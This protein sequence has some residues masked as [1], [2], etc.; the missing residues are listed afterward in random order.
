M[1]WR[2]VE[3]LEF[4]ESLDCLSNEI[5]VLT[6]HCNGVLDPIDTSCDTAITSNVLGQV[7]PMSEQEHATKFQFGI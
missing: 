1:G 7:N 4:V 2:Y 5:N 3:L 6:C